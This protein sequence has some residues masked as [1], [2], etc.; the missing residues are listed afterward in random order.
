MTDSNANPSRSS[1]LPPVA[2]PSEPGRPC[3]IVTGSSAGLGLATAK[4]LL[5]RGWIVLGVA[6]REAPIEAADYHHLKADLAEP[7]VL[8]HAL[9]SLLREPMLTRAARVGLVNNAAKLGPTGPLHRLEAAELNAALTLNLT[10]PS[11]FAARFAAAAGKRPARI[12]NIS[13]GA[14]SSAYP[15]WGSYCLSKSALAMAGEVLAVELAETPELRGRD[16]A[17]LRYAPGVVDTDMQVEARSAEAAD[18]PRVEKFVTLHREG[19]LVPPE[20]PAKEIADFLDSDPV[21]RLT[22]ARYEG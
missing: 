7:E 11:L 2:E 9:E 22:T 12:V 21:E 17:I 15:G 8:N 14:A 1:G 18:C 16:V 19:R 4:A 6:R 5:A 20:A 13:S 10:I 3:A